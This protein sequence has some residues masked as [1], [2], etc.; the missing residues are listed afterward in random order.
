MNFVF[1]WDDMTAALAVFASVIFVLISGGCFVSLTD[2]EQRAREKMKQKGKSE[3]QIKAYREFSRLGFL[4]RWAVVWVV[5]F[6]AGSLVSFWVTSSSQ[7]D[8]EATLYDAIEEYGL[9]SGTK[10]PLYLGGTQNAIGGTAEARG[11]LFSS[12]AVIDLKPSTVVSIG[13]EHNEL[14]WPLALPA[15]RSPFTETNAQPSVEIW[16]HDTPLSM[17]EERFLSQGDD[18]PSV[19]GRVSYEAYWD[20]EW[21]DCKMEFRNL[22]LTCTRTVESETLLVSDEWRNLSIPIFFERYFDRAQINLNPEQHDVL[23]PK[24]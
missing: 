9:S 11:G 22:W 3:Q 7:P 23:F 24:N 4:L 1:T 19:R 12:S 15:D 8:R 13:F 20:V 21:S 18:E 6:A 14:W 16:F 10:Y 5:M 2:R 17:G